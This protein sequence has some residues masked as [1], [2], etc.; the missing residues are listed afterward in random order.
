MTLTTDELVIFH[1]ENGH[2]IT[3]HPG[4][5]L[6]SASQEVTSLASQLWTP[7]AVAEYRAV[8]VGM[9]PEPGPPAPDWE[10]FNLAIL[11]NP[12]WLATAATIRAINPELVPALY[13]ALGQVGG[14]QY[15]SFEALFS[16]VC[17]LADVSQTQRETWAIMAE[18]FSLP[19]GFVKVVRGANGH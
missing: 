7:E 18:D 9:E 17:G 5:D 3:Y 15:G 2:R 16:A 14:G 10:G 4:S 6:S 8:M 13:V 19:A 12:E 11:T 1:E